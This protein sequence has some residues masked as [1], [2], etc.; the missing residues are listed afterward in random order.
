MV[1][2]VEYIHCIYITP[3]TWNWMSLDIQLIDRDKLS[4]IVKAIERENH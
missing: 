4:Q 1:Y 2:H 3:D